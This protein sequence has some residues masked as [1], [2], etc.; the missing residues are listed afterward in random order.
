MLLTA[1]VYVF[2][3]YNSTSSFIN[4]FLIF[5][6]EYVNKF[7]TYNCKTDN[8]IIFIFLATLQNTR[9]DN[10]HQDCSH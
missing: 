4:K 2:F 1:H 7:S 6:N 10:G 9:Y 5:S 8:K 3:K